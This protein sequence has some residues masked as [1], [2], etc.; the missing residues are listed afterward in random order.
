MSSLSDEVISSALY[1]FSKYATEQE[2]PIQ[3]VRQGIN[4]ALTKLGESIGRIL[5]TERPELFGEAIKELQD[6]E[7]QYNT[8]GTPYAYFITVNPKPGTDMAGLKLAMLQVKRKKWFNHYVIGYETT[9]NESRSPHCHIYLLNPHGKP[10]SQ[11][12]REIYN[13][14]KTLCGSIKSVDVQF[15]KKVDEKKRIKYTIKDKNYEVH[16]KF[17]ENLEKNKNKN[18]K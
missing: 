13:S 18:K 7:T 3:H 2:L 11:V 1:H 15:S 14:L 4:R 9:D 12:K 16:G 5:L 17:L 10:V 8:K 6:Y